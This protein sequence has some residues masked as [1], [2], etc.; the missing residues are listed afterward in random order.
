MC[1]INLRLSSCFVTFFI[2]FVFDSY[3][4]DNYTTAREYLLSEEKNLLTKYHL[5]VSAYNTY[6]DDVKASIDKELNNEHN[7]KIVVKKSGENGENLF[8]TVEYTSSYKKMN[9]KMAREYKIP[10]MEKI[11]KA[12]MKN[13]ASHQRITGIR[14]VVKIDSL[15]IKDSIVVSLYNYVLSEDLNYKGKELNY[16]VKTNKY[17]VQKLFLSEKEDKIINHK[18]MYFAFLSVQNIEN[19]LKNK[20]KDNAQIYIYIDDNGKEDASLHIVYTVEF[21]NYFL[22]ELTLIKNIWQKI[23]VIRNAIKIIDENKKQ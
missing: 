10:E 8:I 20:R 3:A 19:L 2:C 11:F 15:D 7:D 6:H 4:Q 1:L 9:S 13:I 18:A 12:I 5:L 16:V 21:K 14:K 22:E 23:E 17:G